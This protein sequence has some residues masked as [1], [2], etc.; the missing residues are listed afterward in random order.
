MAQ[1]VIS[2]LLSSPKSHQ[3]KVD[4][5]IILDNFLL[6]LKQS[7]MKRYKTKP[8]M[9]IVRTLYFNVLEKLLNEHLFLNESNNE[10]IN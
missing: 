2:D 8:A 4:A 3:S 1:S 7:L 10:L 5:N 9:F 6:D